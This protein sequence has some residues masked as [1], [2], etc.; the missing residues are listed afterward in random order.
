M[1]NSNGL[2][3]GSATFQTGDPESYLYVRRGANGDSTI[4]GDLSVAGDLFVAGES[5]LPTIVGIDVS[6]NPIYIKNPKN[7]GINPITE[8]AVIIE[9]GADRTDISGQAVALTLHKPISMSTIGGYEQIGAIQFS[10][11]NSVGTTVRYG[12]VRGVC[13]NPTSGATKGRLEFNVIDNLTHSVR[14]EID[15]SANVIRTDAGARFQDRGYNLYPGAVIIEAA[16]TITKQSSATLVPESSFTIPVGLDGYYSFTAQI[17][18]G[19]VG[20]VADGDNIAIYLDVSG[21]SLSPINGTINI[22]DMTENSANAFSA[23]PGGIIMQRLTAGQ[24]IQLYHSEGGTYTFGSGSIQ[25]AYT[26]LGDSL[27][28]A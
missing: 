10:G 22:L 19:T 18:L 2:T 1:P 23:T 26:Y 13:T 8:S 20:T 21:G 9:G 4:D 14:M 5:T 15:A 24:T 7:L 28:V 3:A 27:V 12:S 25:V 17:S 6:L 11:I 16:G